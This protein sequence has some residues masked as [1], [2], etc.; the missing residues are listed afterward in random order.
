ME[1]MRSEIAAHPPLEGS[2]APRRGDYCLA[3][4]VDGEWCVDGAGGW[5]GEERVPE[6]CE[7]QGRSQPL[8]AEPPPRA[9]SARAWAG[10]LEQGAQCRPPCCVAGCG[11]VGRPSWCSPSPP[12]LPVTSTPLGESQ[13]GFWAR[14]DAPSPTQWPNSLSAQCQAKPPTPGIPPPRQISQGV[15]LSCRRLMPLAVGGPHPPLSPCR[16]RARV[17]KVESPAKVHVFYIDYGNVSVAGG[18]SVWGAGAGR[19]PLPTSTPRVYS[20]V[21]V[22]D[23]AGRPSQGLGAKAFLHWGQR[24]QGSSESPHCSTQ[25]RETSG[26]IVSEHQ[27][28][29]GLLTAG[30][31]VRRLKVSQGGGEAG[32]CPSLPAPLAH[33]EKETARAN[34]LHGHEICLAMG[35]AQWM[36]GGAQ[37]CHSVSS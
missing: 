29:L 1:T 33:G 13:P 32:Q 3:K 10:L 34:G 5:A 27:E 26:V 17:E 9:P 20:V 4:F 14:G 21:V 15:L 22:L 24:G 11:H 36:W 8:F 19:S 37:M 25:R 35:F 30:P 2:Y 6:A 23:L 7:Q 31:V 28:P 18:V 16:Y 12:C